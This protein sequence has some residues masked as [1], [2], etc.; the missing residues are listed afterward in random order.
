VDLYNFHRFDN[1]RHSERKTDPRRKFPVETRQTKPRH[2]EIMEAAAA[3][4]V[5]LLRRH[6]IAGADMDAREGNRRL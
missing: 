2:S 4:D 1:L 5:K 3:G 6:F